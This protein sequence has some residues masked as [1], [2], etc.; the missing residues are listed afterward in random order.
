MYSINF[1]KAKR[2]FMSV[3]FEDEKQDGTPYNHVIC[4]GMPK[5][6]IFD[7][8]LDLD[9]LNT[10]EEPQSRAEKNQINRRKIDAL[11]D[12][13]AAILSNNLAK[14]KITAEWVGDMMNTDEVK[15]FLEEY[16]KFA[17]GEA[18]NPN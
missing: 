18:A 3:T 14:E 2:N 1:Q 4:V 12:T 6:R 8:L 13:V 16:S 17:R 5:K 11:Y 7:R 10:D 9:G 15:E